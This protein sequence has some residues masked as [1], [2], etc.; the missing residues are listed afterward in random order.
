MSEISVKQLA[1]FF[2]SIIILHMAM[3][4]IKEPE[5]WGWAIQNYKCRTK[6]KRYRD[7]N[8]VVIIKNNH[9]MET[10]WKLVT[11]HYCICVYTNT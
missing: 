1:L 4:A 11:D 6:R 10:E 5:E 2:F 8:S 9:S 3:M 7:T